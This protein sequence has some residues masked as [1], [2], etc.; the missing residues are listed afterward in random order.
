MHRL[1]VGLRPPAEIR[2]RL[3]AL[4]GGIPGARW[5][6]DA[7]LHVTLRFVGEVERR[8]A[9][10]VALALSN[11]H[12]PPFELELH[13]VG[14]FDTRGRPNAVWAGV[15]PHAPLEG[16]HKK[17][18]QALVRLGLEPERR[19]YLPHVTLARMN[20]AAG[21][22]SRFLADHA[23]LASPP[24]AVGHFLL[25]ESRLGREGASYEAVGRYPLR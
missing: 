1:F 4:M 24:F 25:F 21:A 22:T 9:E 8:V 10:D 23:G 5:Q 2:Q 17:I 18:D 16:L 20:A 14:E 11:V 6:T 19:T 15:R 3:L 13:G 7:Q 12:C